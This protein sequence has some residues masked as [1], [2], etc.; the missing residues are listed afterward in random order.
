MPGS[1][2]CGGAV[3]DCGRLH[4][5]KWGRWGGAEVRPW[6]RLESSE[7]LWA[8]Q[9]PGRSIAG[10]ASCSSPVAELLPTR[11]NLSGRRSCDIAQQAHCEL[12]VGLSGTTSSPR[13]IEYAM[14]AAVQSLRLCAR[15]CRQPSA[16]RRI[17]S[18]FATPRRTFS[19]TRAWRADAPKRPEGEA[20]EGA[21]A[22]PQSTEPQ[23]SHQYRG[24]S[25]KVS[26]E[27]QEGLSEAEK[28][29]YRELL[30]YADA[31][32]LSTQKQRKPTEQ[33]ME[34]ASDKIE[35]QFFGP[36]L[37][38][39]QREAMRELDQELRAFDDPIYQANRQIRVHRQSFWGEEEEDP[40]MITEDIDDDEFGEDDIMS[41]AHGKLEEHREFREYARIAA[42][43][44]PLLSKL[45]RPFEPPSA[46]EPLR[47]RYTT[48][49]G[50]NHPAQSKVVV[51][52][53]PRDLGLN[54]KQQLKLKKLLGPRW[55]PETDIAKMSCEQFDHQAQNK[56]YLGDLVNKLI[57]QA[58]DPKDTFEDIPLD[59]RHHPKQKKVK[60]PVE[61]RL[62][63]ERMQ[64]IED[65]RQKSLLLDQTRTE[66]GSLVDGSEILDKHFNKPELV[67]IPAANDR[68]LPNISPSR[69][70]PRQR[71]F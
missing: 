70:I 66:A 39:E 35:E 15:A 20:A 58:K 41:M 31:H 51:E 61:W 30:E 29:T 2:G 63:T 9:M 65:T 64:A 57:A 44:M 4:G 49:M 54:D 60:F 59:T 53:S 7:K 38:P 22:V 18:T 21:A 6:A 55:N 43:Q 42:W 28:A 26:L 56:R 69:P 14:V 48:Y 1:G 62:T 45:A 33:Q 10:S 23:A 25:D 17:A 19:S 68:R 13:A 71:R 40:D 12:S 37:S 67:E 16:S 52:F 46:Q 50:E 34:E 36:N 27:L 3:L 11:R 24:R 47:F 5:N 32:N 8:N